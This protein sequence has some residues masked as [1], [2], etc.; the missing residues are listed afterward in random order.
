MPLDDLEPENKT[1]TQEL[2]QTDSDYKFS[3]GNVSDYS[4]LLKEMKSDKK[5]YDQEI[6]DEHDELQ[7]KQ[8]V[9]DNKLSRAASLNTAKFVVNGTDRLLGIILDVI[10]ENDGEIDFSAD[11]EEKREL[12]EY[13]QMMFPDA[14]KSIPP[15]MAF[16][17]TLGL[18]YGPKIKD[19]FDN[20]KLKK[21]LEQERLQNIEMQ[22]DN[23]LLREKLK[24]HDR[25]SKA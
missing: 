8:S 11:K 23:D 18:V 24:N 4:D 1:G 16:S 7:I 21:A 20:R 13:A 12:I 9:G 17:I 15:W 25:D 19:A 2:A 22:R 14:S 10:S 6:T 5:I 3:T